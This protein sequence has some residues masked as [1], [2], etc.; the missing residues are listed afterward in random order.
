MAAEAEAVVPGCGLLGSDHVGLPGAV[1]LTG[2]A[3]ATISSGNLVKI[4]VCAKGMRLDRAN[5]LILTA[6][7][8]ARHINV[9]AAAHERALSRVGVVFE[10]QLKAF[11]IV[12]Y[13]ASLYAI[14]LRYEKDFR[15]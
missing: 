2:A 13:E 8:Q 7:L 5:W 12:T 15:P 4:G 9:A 10:S 11:R 3:L 6:P 1:A 14:L